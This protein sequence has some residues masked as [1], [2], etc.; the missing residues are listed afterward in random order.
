MKYLPFV[1]IILG[2]CAY[3]VLAV[4]RRL[5]AKKKNAPSAPTDRV[6][7]VM[8]GGTR[9]VAARKYEYEGAED[10]T[11]AARLFGGSKACKYGCIGLGSCAAAC[12][13]GAIHIIGGA[14]AVDT[15]KCRGCGKCAAVCPKGIIELVP[16][17]ARV[18]V[19]CSSR[20]AGDENV[21]NCNIGCDNCGECIKAC[22][23]NALRVESGRV[24]IDYAL[25]DFCGKCAEVCARKTVWMVKE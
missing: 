6:A 19:G 24:H 14:A 21:K 10:C 23:K 7:R 5:E 18:W 25:C 9:A 3:A 16:K 22:E 4:R 8:C 17:N 12:P 13:V 1:I 15:A 20:A 11:A 2:L